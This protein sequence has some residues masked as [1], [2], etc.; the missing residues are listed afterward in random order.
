MSYPPGQVPYGYPPP[1]PP[2]PSPPTSSKA[3]TALVLG[4]LSLFC[5]GFFAGIPAI[6]V[7]LSAR[8]EIRQSNG[9]VGGDG[10]A[11]GGIITGILGILWSL[12]VTVI[13]V[14]LLAIGGEVADQYGDAC[15][16][17]RD[18]QGDTFFGE[19]IGPEDCP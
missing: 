3:T 15:D 13:L 18:G 19:T 12:V 1:V 6:V 4:V 8:K 17:V 5:F 10:L 2:T 14:S 16:N 11:L 7:G 9:S